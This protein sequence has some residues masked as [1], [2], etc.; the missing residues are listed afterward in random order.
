MVKRARYIE[1]GGWW[2]SKGDCNYPPSLSL[3]LSLNVVV[4]NGALARKHLEVLVRFGGRPGVVSGC[5]VG[6]WLK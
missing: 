4:S 6:S 5:G 2:N 1:I 3:S